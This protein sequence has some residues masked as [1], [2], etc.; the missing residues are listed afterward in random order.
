MRPYRAGWFA[1]LAGCL[2]AQDP[3]D[4]SLRISADNPLGYRL[5]GDRC[6]GLYIEQVA[7]SIWVASFHRG[8]RTFRP[9]TGK[10]IALTWALPP[11]AQAHIQAVAL[12]PGVAYRMDSVRPRGAGTYEWPADLLAAAGLIGSDLGLLSW[13][14]LPLGAKPVKVHSPVSVNGQAGA[15]ELILLPDAALQEVFLSLTKLDEQGKERGHL[16]SDRALGYGYYPARRPVAIRLPLLG[17]DGF[18]RAA[19]GASLKTGG[20]AVTDFHFWHK[21]RP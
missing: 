16:F 20:S 6:E 18:Y 1:M 21:G 14:A 9:E 17:E 4:P 11:S 15:L 10:R 8:A 12:K 19:I 13:Y 3:C 5:R 7:G 2:L